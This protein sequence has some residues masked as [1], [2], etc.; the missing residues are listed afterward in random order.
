M[1]CL[2][3]EK[4]LRL[5]PQGH[6]LRG[7]YGTWNDAIGVTFFERVLGFATLFKLFATAALQ[8]KLKLGIK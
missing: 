1:Y 5:A 6:F 8:N 2:V 7:V 3:S 4:P